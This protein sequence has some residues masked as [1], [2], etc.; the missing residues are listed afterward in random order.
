MAVM[1]I[2]KPE[3]N[4]LQLEAYHWIAPSFINEVSGAVHLAGTDLYT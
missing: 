4:A 3:A 2:A 1:T